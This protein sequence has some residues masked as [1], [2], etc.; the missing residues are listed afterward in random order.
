MSID[1][2]P[3]GGAR[4]GMTVTTEVD[5]VEVDLVHRSGPAASLALALPRPPD[6]EIRV[7]YVD[8]FRQDTLGQPLAVEVAPGAEPRVLYGRFRPRKIDWPTSLPETFS[9]RL[10]V[11][12]LRLAHGPD[13]PQAARLQGLAA[14]LALVFGCPA[15]A[16]ELDPAT[17]PEPWPG[18]TLNL[19][20]HADRQRKLAGMIS[21][22]ERFALSRGVDAR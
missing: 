6:F 5:G 15:E 3:L 7:E 17:S 14:A 20:E 18:I 13:D 4:L 12:G 11:H 16:R 1:G 19:F 22:A 10:E 2:W 8:W 9:R 21:L